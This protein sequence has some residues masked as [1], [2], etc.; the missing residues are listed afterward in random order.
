MART[1]AGDFLQT[2]RFAVACAAVGGDALLQTGS[3]DATFATCTTP[4][5]TLD[6]VEY[7][8]NSMD[9]KRKFPGNPTYNDITLTKGTIVSDTALHFWM[10][11]ART[12]EEFRTT[13]TI[14]HQDKAGDTVHTYT[15]NE[16]FPMRVKY[17]GDFDANSSEIT[18][19][20]MDISYES[21]TYAGKAA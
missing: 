13:L 3:A 1:I 20:E 9:V 21:L 19:Q 18:I 2:H 7:K 10:E 8:D 4:E 6:V 11:K 12:K 14:T 15:L 16:C 17:D 5:V